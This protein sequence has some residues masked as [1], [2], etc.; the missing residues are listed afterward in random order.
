MLK[1]FRYSEQEYNDG[2][3]AFGSVRVGTLHDFRQSE[4]KNGI[5]DANEGIKSV[6]H[7]IPHVTERDVGSIHLKA[8]EEFNFIKYSG[9]TNIIIKD[10]QV[11]REFNHPDCFVHC[12]S[13]SF[14]KVV[15]SQFD[16][17]DSCVEISDVHGF[18]RRLTATLSLHVPV[19]LI[20]IRSVAYMSRDEEWNGKDWGV[21]PALIKE[22]RFSKQ[23]E[24]RA[25]WKP[26]FN[27]PIAPIV[28]ND[29]GLINYCKLR[30]L[31]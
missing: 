14:S 12:V 27:G 31:P 30:A 21:H 19:D 20:A 2:L 24:F 8:L 16:R 10:V 4:H 13:T 6:S 29:I 1:V 5:A 3:L 28:I 23:V 18:Y 7:Y 26:R 17:A 25:I 9:A 15:L 22:P 11:T